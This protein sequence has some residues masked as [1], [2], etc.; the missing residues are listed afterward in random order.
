MLLNQQIIASIFN[1]LLKNNPNEFNTTP[2]DFDKIKDVFCTS[3]DLF[4]LFHTDSQK[5]IQ[6][7]REHKL[8]SRHTSAPKRREA[9]EELF[10]PLTL[11]L[12]RAGWV[13]NQGWAPTKW[14]K[15]TPFWD[16]IFE[17][18]R[19]KQWFQSGQE[20]GALNQHKDVDVARFFKEKLQNQ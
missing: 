10:L 3:Y 18:K 16:K 20:F 9:S 7:S 14:I 19:A 15:N 8:K 4:P 5:T 6:L 17:E 1:R 11:M 13:L 12:M 2:F